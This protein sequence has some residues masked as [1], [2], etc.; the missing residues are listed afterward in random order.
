[1]D[2]L[3]SALTSKRIIILFFLKAFDIVTT[4]IGVSIY[5]L[6][7]EGNPRVIHSLLHGYFWQ[8]QLLMFPLLIALGLCMEHI[9]RNKDHSK[10][11]WIL[12]ISAKSV[13]GF[14]IVLMVIVGIFNTIGLFLG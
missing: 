4:S 2:Y 11:T 14:L 8:T 5:G 3:K 6:Y 10:I 13:M 12:N 9:Q 7:W 1:M